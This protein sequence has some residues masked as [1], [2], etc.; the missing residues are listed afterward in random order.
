MWH[1]TTTT[2]TATTTTTAT[3]TAA[4]AAA[5]TAT[6]SS[7]NVL[8]KREGRPAEEADGEEGNR[9]RYRAG[10]LRRR[11]R[12]R[13][14][15]E[16]EGKG[17]GGGGG[18]GGEKKMAYPSECSVLSYVIARQIDDKIDYCKSL[19]NA[20]FDNS[21]NLYRKDLL[22]HYGCVNAIEFSNQGDLLVSGESASSRRV[23]RFVGSRKDPLCDSRSLSIFSFDRLTRRRDLI[24]L[25]RKINCLYRARVC[26]IFSSNFYF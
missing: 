19:M 15:C 1:G 14:S 6:T 25:G 4:A 26:M 13:Q 8:W 9:V 18:G 7:R 22:S 11:R 2:V 20:R 21:E 12:R 3:T 17:K 16:G 24:S 23:V 5:A 10:G